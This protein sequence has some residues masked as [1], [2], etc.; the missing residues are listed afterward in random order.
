M[1]SVGERSTLVIRKFRITKE[2]G[3]EY[4]E[5]YYFNSIKL[6]RF[7]IDGIKR[8][9]QIWIKI[10]DSDALAPKSGL[11]VFVCEGDMHRLYE[12]H[13]LQQGEKLCKYFQDDFAHCSGCV[14]VEPTSY[15]FI[16]SYP[17]ESSWS[18]YDSMR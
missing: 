11:Y 16:D 5:G 12:L 10:L 17:D 3:T 4:L 6:Y 8:V 7:R 14:T 9:R 18:P 2:K 15:H 1:W 13:R